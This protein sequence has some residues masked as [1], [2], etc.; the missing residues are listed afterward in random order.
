MWQCLAVLHGA[1]RMWWYLYG[2]LELG[3][4]HRLGLNLVPVLLVTVYFI[5]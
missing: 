5:I 1:Q 3:A 2:V 4:T